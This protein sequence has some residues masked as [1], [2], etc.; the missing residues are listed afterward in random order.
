MLNLSSSSEINGEEVEKRRTIVVSRAE[1]DV[2]AVLMTMKRMEEEEDGVTTPVVV[3]PGEEE[4]AQAQA[5]VETT[6]TLVEGEETITIHEGGEVAQWSMEITTT[7]TTVGTGET[8]EMG[9]TGAGKGVD[10]FPSNF[11]VTVKVPMISRSRS[12]E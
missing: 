9:R 12:D 7:I 6:T 8:K 10:P 11:A 5:Q 2:V 3:I 1:A 4:E